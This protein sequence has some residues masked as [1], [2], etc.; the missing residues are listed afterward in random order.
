[1][2]SKYCHSFIFTCN[3]TRGHYKC[4]FKI[5]SS[6]LC[7]QIFKF[8]K[9]LIMNQISFDFSFIKH[10]F[11]LQCLNNAIIFFFFHHFIEFVQFAWLQHATTYFFPFMKRNTI[12]ICNVFPFFGRVYFFLYLKCTIIVKN[13]RMICQLPIMTSKLSYN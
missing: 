12:F 3:Y 4:L 2:I 13:T 8:N 11:L 7:C 1:M 10:Y 6:L 9:L 5:L